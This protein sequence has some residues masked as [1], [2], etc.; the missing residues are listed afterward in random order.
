[1]AIYAAV[2]GATRSRAAEARQQCGHP[3]YYPI[4]DYEIAGISTSMRPDTRG[5]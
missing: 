4:N 3:R 2:P 1:M 5:C